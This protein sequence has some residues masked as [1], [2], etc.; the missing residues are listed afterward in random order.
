MSSEVC[1][2]L[3]FW[4]WERCRDTGFLFLFFLLLLHSLPCSSLPSTGHLIKT[5]LFLFISNL[6]SG[7]LR[8]YIRLACEWQSASIS[9]DLG[10]AHGELRYRFNCS[11]NVK[12]SSLKPNSVLFSN[13]KESVVI[14]IQGISSKY[15]NH[16]CLSFTWADPGGTGT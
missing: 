5:P 4:Y 11:G 16:R 8:V 12:L 14:Y 7:K 6:W 2:M 13:L 9:V 1:V 10:I 3:H 15:H